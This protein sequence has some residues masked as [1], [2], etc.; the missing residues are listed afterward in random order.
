[1]SNA[2]APGR[3]GNTKKVII[4]NT[5]ELDKRAVKR[6]KMVAGLRLANPQAQTL[7]IIV[8]TL[9]ISSSGAKVGALR[10]WIE[11]GTI[12]CV[13]R[14]HTRAQCRVKWSRQLAPGEVQIGIEFLGHEAR[15]WGLDLDEGC[16]E[17]WLSASER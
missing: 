16:A 11:P 3:G 12:L 10:E 7:D 17:V 4:M 1:M 13:Q 6:T 9:D 14:R 5:R 2:T 8:H 15:F